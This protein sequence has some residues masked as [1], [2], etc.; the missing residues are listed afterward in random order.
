VQ[1]AILIVHL[2]VKNIEVHAVLNHIESV[3]SLAE[4]AVK[5]ISS[6]KPFPPVSPYDGPQPKCLL[7]PKSLIKRR[8]SRRESGQYSW[9]TED[10]R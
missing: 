2:G 5:N 7:Q 3:S 8:A 6:V 9:A 1:L 4:N 10:S